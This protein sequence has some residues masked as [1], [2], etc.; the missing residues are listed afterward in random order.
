[1]DGLDLVAVQGALKI[2]NTIVQ[3][4]QFFSAQLSLESNSHILAAMEQE[5]S[6]EELPHVQGKEARL[7]FSG[8]AVKR[9]PASKVRETK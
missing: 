8:A 7:R 4:H 3:K 6:W 1:M 5:R 9:D 2:F